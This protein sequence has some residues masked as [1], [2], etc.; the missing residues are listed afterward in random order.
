VI[1][2]RNGSNYPTKQFVWGKRYV[3]ELV[4]TSINSNPWSSSHTTCDM[5]YW[6][7]QDA[8]WNV[9]G[10]VDAD[11]VLRERYEY[12]P[13]GERSVFMSYGTNDPYCMEPTLASQQP[14]SVYDV[15]L[16]TSLCEAGHQGLFHDEESGLV[17]DRARYINPTTGRFLSRDIGY[18]DSYNSYEYCRTGPIDGLDPSGRLDWEWWWDLT[19]ATASNAYWQAGTVGYGVGSG[20]YGTVTHPINTYWSAVDATSVVSTRALED[21]G[22]MWSAGF[23]GFAFELNSA[24]GTTGVAEGLTGTD[25]M[26]GNDLDPWDRGER[27]AQGLAQTAFSFAAAAN[28]A[29]SPKSCPNWKCFP[30]GTR[31]LIASESAKGAAQVTSVGWD[32][33]QLVFGAILV[34]AGPTGIYIFSRRRRCTYVLAK[35]NLEI[36]GRDIEFLNPL[37]SDLSESQ[38]SQL[39]NEPS[40]IVGMHREYSALKMDK[41]N[42]P[43]VRKHP[44]PAVMKLSGFS[45]LGAIWLIICMALGGWVIAKAAPSRGV[46]AQDTRL[47]AT[48]DTSQFVTKNIEDIRVGDYVL[49]KEPT[50]QGPPTPHRVIGLP[51]NWTE[52]LVH[53]TVSGG[54]ELQATREH[55]FWVRQKGWVYA[56]YLKPGDNLEDA[57]GHAVV[58]EAVKIENRIADTY[59][60]TVE[61]VHT[62]YILAGDE[63]VLV[64]NAYIYDPEDLQNLTIYGPN[65]NDC[66]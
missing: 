7:C 13:Y 2:E 42:N 30:A 46:S 35:S 52:H 26:S 5:P 34:G 29:E 4:Q 63:S 61:D 33:R 44:R 51:R 23:D 25:L 43:I 27:A 47:S 55:P 16:P 37:S 10:V 60:L 6:V 19:E 14:M 8:N 17:H 65:L 56:K 59:N 39:A 1:E 50:E 38:L 64:H 57:S 11:G 28:M 41:V 49:A 58:V 40:Y 32:I 54:S 20:I 18:P 3:D 24:V 22:S 31:V 48:Q 21:N 12:T 15:P 45:S 36:E 9:L 53:V 62:F 66:A